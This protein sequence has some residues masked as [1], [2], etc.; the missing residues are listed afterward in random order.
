MI[1]HELGH[2]VLDRE[3]SNTLVT[4]PHFGYQIPNSIM[5]Y[6]AFGESSFYKTFREHYVSELNNPEKQL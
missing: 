5:Y 2:C 1:Y 3:H 4:H 6:M